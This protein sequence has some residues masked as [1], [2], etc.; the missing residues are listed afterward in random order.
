ML[1]FDLPSIFSLPRD[2]G[3]HYVLAAWALVLILGYMSYRAFA[4]AG[5][6]NWRFKAIYRKPLLG[7]VLIFAS[8]FVLYSI[9]S[10]LSRSG[11]VPRIQDEFAYL[12]G[13]ET[14]AEGRVTNA[15]HPMS[16]HFEAFYVLTEPT[17]MS[18]YPPAQSVA[19]AIGLVLFGSPSAGVWL[20]GAAAC[21]A[22]Y[23]MMLGCFSRRWALYGALLGMTS[24]A[25]F[26]WNQTFLGGNV[27]FLGGALAL[28]S[29]F[30]IMRDARW[31][32]P[33]TLAAGFAIVANSRPYE[34]LIFAVVL[35]AGLAVW[36]LK[37]GIAKHG[38]G[39]VVSRIIIPFAIVSAIN[40]AWIG[41][42]NYRV[43]G[44]PLKMPYAAY[45]Q[46]S[47]SVPLF[48]FS[49][50][51]GA[52]SP[53]CLMEFHNSKYAKLYT[54][55]LTPA[56]FVNQQA[57]RLLL[58]FMVLVGIGCVVPFVLG[59]V[60]LVRSRRFLLPALVCASV[61]G[62]ALTTYY[63]PHYI[64][65]ALPSILVI[66]V[67]GVMFWRKWIRSRFWR[68]AVYLIPFAQLLTIMLFVGKQFAAPIN[69]ETPRERIEA[70]LTA[71]PSRHLIVVEDA[72][73]YDSW[74]FL[75]NDANIDASRIVW[76][77]K[78]SGPEDSELR[79]YYSDRAQWRLSQVDGK[80]VLRAFD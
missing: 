50:S 14:F 11:I 59:F 76:A 22:V 28:G 5:P 37:T 39:S 51:D 71:S 74:I 34:G 1:L 32:H 20:S 43:T 6:F 33:A 3:V 48:L 19:I 60:F 13:A 12:L 72:C 29:V 75:Y 73:V 27:A 9:P 2:R 35:L 42:Y 64:A 10:I 26:L 17:Y 38:L 70:Q 25:V 66:T 55:F 69:D 21:V 63:H 30:R 16:R 77:R 47:E 31:F 40:F 45:G 65:H 7:A 68:F 41:H 54:A 52:R 44:D 57:G 23:W 56:G 36:A 80:F 49:S 67:Y 24:H 8:S 4:K 79:N 62:S 53:N 61:I 18:K 78:L 58:F 46:K 15:R